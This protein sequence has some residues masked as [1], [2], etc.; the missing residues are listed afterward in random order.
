MYYHI[1]ILKKLLT[2]GRML[3]VLNSNINTFG[4]NAVLNAFVQHNT[5]GAWSYIV[6]NT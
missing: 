5:N 4:Q 6:N 3:H 2:A 1:Y